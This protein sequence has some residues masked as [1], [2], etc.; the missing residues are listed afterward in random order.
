MIMQLD[1]LDRLS[2]DLIHNYA[3]NAERQLLSEQQIQHC[4]SMIRTIA[5]M[6]LQTEMW[7][8]SSRGLQHREMIDVYTLRCEIRF[9]TL[10]H[11]LGGKGRGGWDF[12][13]DGPMPD[14]PIV[15]YKWTYPVPVTSI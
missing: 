9:K 3:G 2:F 1:D 14:Q 6:L 10:R 15:P 13:E 5:M 11:W 12:D 4:R 8:K 7:T